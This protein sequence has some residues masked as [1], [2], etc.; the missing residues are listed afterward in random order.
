V[1]VAGWGTLKPSHPLLRFHAR[2][3]G[4]VEAAQHRQIWGVTL[5]PATPTF[6][7]LLILQKYLRSVADD[8]DAAAAALQK[9]LGWRREFGLDGPTPIW[10]ETFE[11]FDGLGYVTHLSSG[12]VVTWNLYGAVKDL[13]ATFGDLDK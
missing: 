13:G 9:T 2:L 6:A 4:I 1:T 12:E 8:L 5:D 10:E 3:G 11:G 7:T